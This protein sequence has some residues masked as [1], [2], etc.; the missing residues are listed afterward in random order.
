MRELFD[1]WL[2]TKSWDKAGV[3]LHHKRQK[4]ESVV[5]Q[6]LEI[7]NGLMRGGSIS[8]KATDGNHDTVAIQNY[9]F[10][11]THV[12][13]SGIMVG[14]GDTAVDI[15]DYA[16]EA[17]IA[18][19]TGAG[20]LIYNV[21]VIPTTVTIS[22]PDAYFE[23]YRNFSNNSG[24]SITVKETGMYV[25]AGAPDDYYMIVRDVPTEVVVPDG[26]GCYVK[27]TLKVSE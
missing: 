20:E 18:H 26:G 27:Y 25:K 12:S 24:G 9:N 2:E 5:L 15:E 8:I 4:S 22:D 19:G 23:P 1:L 16:L 6:F 3:I 11:M 21:I 7:L 14:T 17:V 13:L 10:A